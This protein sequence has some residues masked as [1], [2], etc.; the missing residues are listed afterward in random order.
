SAM[1]DDFNTREAIAALFQLSRIS[2]NYDYSVIDNEVLNEV[3]EIFE[4]YGN[5][6]L[7]LFTVDALDLNLESKIEQL[8]LDRDEARKS[9]DWSK[10]DSIRDK[11]MSMGIEI[12][13]T[14]KGTK[15]RKI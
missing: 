15:W 5:G 14:P 3:I 4:V 10:S 12:Q 7:G 2:N 8:I 6:V 1:N 11:L 9:K 13:D